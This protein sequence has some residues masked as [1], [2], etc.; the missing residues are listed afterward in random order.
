MQTI[1]FDS[2]YD[3]ALNQ[4]NERKLHLKQLDVAMKR[5]VTLTSEK[6]FD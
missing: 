1:S 3:D 6:T 4:S 2:I 5:E